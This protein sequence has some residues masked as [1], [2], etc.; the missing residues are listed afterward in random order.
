MIL[1]DALASF[2]GVDSLTLGALVTAV[3]AVLLL[4]RESLAAFEGCQRWRKYLDFS[5][6]PVFLAFILILLARFVRL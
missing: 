1:L 3:L 4:T 2:V 6:V 5:I